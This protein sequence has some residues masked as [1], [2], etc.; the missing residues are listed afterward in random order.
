M[1]CQDTHSIMPIVQVI[2]AVLHWKCVFSL[3]AVDVFEYEVNR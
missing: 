3:G 1:R 2:A